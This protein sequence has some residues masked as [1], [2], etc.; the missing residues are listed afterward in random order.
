LFIIWAWLLRSAMIHITYTF[1]I[2]ALKWSLWWTNNNWFASFVAIKIIFHSRAATILATIRLRY[3][4]S[5]WNFAIT[6]FYCTKLIRA[7]NCIRA[8]FAFTIG[9][10]SNT[11]IIITSEW[12]ISFTFLRCTVLF[13]L[14]TCTVLTFMWL[15]ARTH[16]WHYSWRSDISTLC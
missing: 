12:L 1:L 6:I 13:I 5:V 4:T 14:N 8:T 10:F 7:N 16:I 15:I 2:S 3:W 11:W 9:W